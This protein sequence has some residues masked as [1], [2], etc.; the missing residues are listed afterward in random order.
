MKAFILFIFFCLY[1]NFGFGQ[2]ESCKYRSVWIYNC[3][4]K[5]TKKVLRKPILIGIEF[6][7]S[8][9]KNITSITFNE[10]GYLRSTN[11]SELDNEGNPIEVKS[12]DSAGYLSNSI[13]KKYDSLS[14]RFIAII[15]VDKHHRC[16]FDNMKCVR[17][18]CNRIIEQTTYGQYS[19]AMI[20]KYKYEYK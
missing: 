4:D 20:S 11:I 2:S 6:C 9:L 8:E 1:N 17:D 19:K 7:N 18:K 15:A 16:T 14:K 3:I 5:D 13:L 12:Y 10:K